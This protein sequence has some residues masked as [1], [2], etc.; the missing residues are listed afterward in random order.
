[1]LDNH[2]LIGNMFGGWPGWPNGP[3]AL[4]VGQADATVAPPPPPSTLVAPGMGGFGMDPGM[5]AAMGLY[6][7][8]GPGWCGPG[9]GIDPNLVAS[10]VAARQSNLLY[11]DCPNQGVD[12]FLG[13]ECNVKICPGDTV[14]VTATPQII[15]KPFRLIIPSTIAGQLVVRQLLV[16]NRPCFAGSGCIPGLAFAENST[17]SRFNSETAW[18]NQPITG[19]FT[20]T[21]DAEV[22]FQATLVGKGMQPGNPRISG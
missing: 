15:F 16:G 19:T 22:C 4:G 8:G 1:M 3:F 2:D 7:G 11:W 10:L 12:E 18:V 20:N 14:D 6:Y 21:S 13:F 9:A 5:A 17:Y